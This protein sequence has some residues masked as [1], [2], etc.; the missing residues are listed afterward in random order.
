MQTPYQCCQIHPTPRPRWCDDCAR[1]MEKAGTIPLEPADVGILQRRM[2]PH[3]GRVSFRL[4]EGA[5]L[6]IPADR[7]P[8]T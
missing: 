2:D 1:D 7:D 5:H 4:R 3:T 8:W 6:E